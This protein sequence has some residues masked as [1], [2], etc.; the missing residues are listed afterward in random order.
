MIL[1]LAAVPHQPILMKENI[2]NEGGSKQRIKSDWLRKWR[3]F[4]RPITERKRDQKTPEHRRIAL[5]TQ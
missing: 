3:Q 2:I 1:N 5:A 4:S